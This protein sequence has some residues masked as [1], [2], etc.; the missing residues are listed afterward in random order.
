MNCSSLVIRTA[1][2]KVSRSAETPASSVS[3]TADPQ[4]LA[5]TDAHCR[6]DRAMWLLQLAAPLPWAADQAHD[7]TRGRLLRSRWSVVEAAATACRQPAAV[8][9]P[10]SAHDRTRRT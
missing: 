7:G 9:A 4:A 10:C 8:A 2:P 1:S 5:Q 6:M 3:P